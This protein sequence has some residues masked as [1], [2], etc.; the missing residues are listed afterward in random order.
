MGWGASTAV[1]R[2]VASVGR[3]IRCSAR[4]NTILLFRYVCVAT[5]G[6][7]KHQKTGAGQLETV[8]LTPSI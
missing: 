8:L 2:S 5:L 3:L 1:P 4:E 7:E 6:G